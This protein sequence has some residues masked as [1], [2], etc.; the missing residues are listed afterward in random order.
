MSYQKYIRGEPPQT[1]LVYYIYQR[2][3]VFN[4]VTHTQGYDITLR[5]LTIER[6]K[7]PS[8]GTAQQPEC[9][10]QYGA[11]RQQGHQQRR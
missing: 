9:H 5:R 7:V 1:A 8:E 4:V 3:R 10:Q 11:S 6:W 2:Q